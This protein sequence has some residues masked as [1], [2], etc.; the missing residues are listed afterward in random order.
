MDKTE[1]LM[2]TRIVVC[3]VL[4]FSIGGRARADTIVLKDGTRVEVGVA[5]KEGGEIK[6]TGE[7]ALVSFPE[8]QVSHVEEAERSPRE[9]SP[10]GG[11]RFDVWSAGLSAEDVMLIAEVNDIPLH[12]TG[13][14][15]AGKHFNP[16]VS[17]KYMK[18]ATGYYYQHHLM[19]RPAKVSL[20][21]TPLSKILYRVSV[22]F[23]AA[24]NP[25]EAGK[26]IQDV[27]EK[28]YGKPA[29]SEKKDPLRDRVVWR[30]GRSSEVSLVSGFNSLRV[31]YTDSILEERKREEEGK[32]KKD[33]IRSR[34]SEDA[35]KF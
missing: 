33:E 15:S 11:F 32:I 20:S 6:G 4:L 18:T 31:V 22:D 28:K 8:E 13:M 26:E 34:Q 5:W 12:R 7:S 3:L 2:V 9:E 35:H 16:E 17:R 21:M 30:I 27:L 14:I 10:A 24:P 23:K 1:S 29:A 25:A 19:G